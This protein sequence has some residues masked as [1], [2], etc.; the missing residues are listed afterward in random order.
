[1]RWIFK[2]LI[3]TIPRCERSLEKLLRVPRWPLGHG[4]QRFGTHNLNFSYHKSYLAYYRLPSTKASHKYIVIVGVV[5]RVDDHELCSRI[6]EE[7]FQC[8]AGADI[9]VD[10]GSQVFF[11]FPDRV[12]VEAGVSVEKWGVEYTSGHTK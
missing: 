7:F 3:E 12:E 2:N 8:P 1:M 11:A 4:D 10:G 5:G 9:G 6:G